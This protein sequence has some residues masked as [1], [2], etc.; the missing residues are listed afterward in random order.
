[1]VWGFLISLTLLIRPI[2]SIN[3]ASQGRGTYA[4]T[5]R[6]PFLSRW[7]KF[8]VSLST[9]CG[10]NSVEHWDLPVNDF[11]FT[12]TL[13]KIWTWSK[14]CEF[15]GNVSIYSCLLW[16]TPFLEEWEGVWAAAGEELLKEHVVHKNWLLLSGR[17][18]EWGQNCWEICW[19]SSQKL[20]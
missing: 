15:L 12:R 13:C 9:Q 17:Q 7:N 1:M 19:T 10:Q 4:V 2:R 14:A 16:C 20:C 5:W 3:K 18:S 8:G 11:W 6:L